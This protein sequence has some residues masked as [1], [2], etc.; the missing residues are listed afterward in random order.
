MSGPD[1][2]GRP[3][4][5]GPPQ[6]RATPPLDG[7]VVADFSRV[8][9]GPL[10]TMILAD[11]G[12]DVI[13]VERPGVGDDTRSWGPPWR[14]DDSTYSLAMNRNKRS[15]TLD[16]S[17][18]DDLVLARRLA[19][20]ADVLVENFRPGNAARFGLDHDSLSARNPG[21]ISAS[22]SGFGTGEDAAALGGYDFLIQAVSGL[23][24]I[25]GD[26]DGEP[27]K[28]GVALVDV[29]CG[30]Y[31][32]IGIQ[33]A[34]AER[35]RSGQGQQVHVSLM[36][37]SLASLVNQASAFLGAGVVPG[38]MGNRHPSIAPYE[39]FQAAD[40]PFAIAVGSDRLFALLAGELG[41]SELADDPRFA[42]NADR[43]ANR[44]GLVTAMAPV[45]ATQPA[46]HWV[47]RLRAR[48]V[49][50]GLVNTVAEA[51]DEAAALGLDPIVEA[52]R[53]D[54]GS[55]PTVRS[56][57]DLSRTPTVVDRAP[58][59]LGEHDDEVRG[60]LEEPHR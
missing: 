10:A 24:S 1:V 27:T 21:L 58:P 55:V 59:D 9:A 31:T 43:V 41:L 7:I 53:R 28:V 38:R 23:M 35:A 3:D 33:G 44:D 22:V 60:W 2:T 56:P 51:F 17:D 46:G 57:I 12:A 4:D 8:L 54:G 40:R 37:A 30:L 39:T 26:A 36:G 15:V 42:T 5:V 29:V 49:P 14:G 6:Q 19:E 34:L 32:A 48:G 13:K 16:L 45:L 20:R 25:T 50:A 47:E 52:P 11:L 18:P